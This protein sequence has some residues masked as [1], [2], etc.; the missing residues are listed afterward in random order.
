[1]PYDAEAGR[2][3]RERGQEALARLNGSPPRE[4]ER[5]ALH[6]AAGEVIR[7]ASAHAV[8]GRDGRL[9][10]ASQVAQAAQETA[11]RYGHPVMLYG[12]D[13]ARTA[14]ERSVMV[15]VLAQPDGTL[16][17]TEVAEMPRTE[18]LSPEAAANVAGRDPGE[19][20][21]LIP[22]ER[23]EPRDM[24]VPLGMIDVPAGTPDPEN[25]LVT[26]VRAFGVFQPVA[27]R[28]HGRRY[29]I[30]G[31][32]RR[33]RAATLAG[34]TLIPAVVFPEHTPRHVA[35]AMTLAENFI[36][37][38]NP[39]S[40]LEAIEGLVV[41]GATEQQ[42]TREL[43]ISRQTLQARMR[44]SRLIPRLRLALADGHM[45]AAVA[46]LASRLDTQRQEQLAIMLQEQ[47][48][49]G[50]ARPSIT[51]RMV[52]ELRQVRQQAQVDAIPDA[53]FDT[54][55]PAAGPPSTLA[56]ETDGTT[57]R[58]VLR[59]TEWGTGERRRIPEVLELRFVDE[60]VEYRREAWMRE[61]IAQ[62][63]AAV[64][65][66]DETGGTL[67][68]NN[69]RYVRETQALARIELARLD[70]RADVQIQ[71]AVAA[72]RPSAPEVRAE[73]WTGVHELLAQA[74][75]MLPV[76]PDGD[77]EA[78]Y[79]H[80]TDLMERVAR[81]AR[82]EAQAQRTAAAPGLEQAVV[83]MGG[84]TVA[85]AQESAAQFARRALIR[86][87]Y[88]LFEIEGQFMRYVD[89]NGRLRRR[90]FSSE[91]EFWTAV[92]EAMVRERTRQEQ[93]GNR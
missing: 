88:P 91:T 40:E 24:R 12:T 72:E 22:E 93:G 74:E 47:I 62:S 64:S 69:S 30:I 78:A 43:G 65:D 13:L 31:G 44:L 92:S 32:R 45:G 52:R 26:S 54:P 3:A 86:G 90:H 10:S 63:R 50:E 81:K 39:L 35:Y 85:Q 61:Q 60:V 79:F 7:Q 11:R 37:R 33:V 5:E 83:A 76:S 27:L 89:G 41:E 82:E 77:S 28:A 6:A 66:V 57:P 34:L 80:L 18:T 55:A 51:A 48:A 16:T 68:F 25:D 70:G 19:Q 42:I 84:Q 67:V 1:M 46:D 9:A 38:A 8:V 71:Q 14:G 2:R 49:A 36:R 58:Y 17:I 59:A 56:L 29:E 87:S 15:Q 4:P 73:S 53:V 21:S 20:F 23:I 75:A